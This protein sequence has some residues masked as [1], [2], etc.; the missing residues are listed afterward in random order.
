VAGVAIEK[1]LEV[2]R[3]TT[4]EQVDR[5]GSLDPADSRAIPAPPDAPDLDG[6]DTATEKEWKTLLGGE[7]KHEE[8]RDFIGAIVTIAEDLWAPF[9]WRNDKRRGAPY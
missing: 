8:P 9:G 5:Y 1:G 4:S 6:I 7:V 2:D 3:L